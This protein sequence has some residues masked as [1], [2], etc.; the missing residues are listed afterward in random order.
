VDRGVINEKLVEEIRKEV[1]VVWF[2]VLSEFS[3]TDW[4]KSLKNCVV[5]TRRS[6]YIHVI[7]TQ[8]IVRRSCDLSEV[9]K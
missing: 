1:A 3:L 4:R 5:F 8:L 6:A 9:L 2:K 7:H